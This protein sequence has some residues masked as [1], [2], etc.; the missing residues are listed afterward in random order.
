MRKIFLAILIVV[1]LLSVACAGDAPASSEK[2]LN[3][4]MRVCIIDGSP[5]IRLALKGAYSIC[6]IDTGKAIMDGSLLDTVVTGAKDG[7]LIGDKELKTYGVAVK[8]EKDSTIYVDG[9][10]FRGEIDVITKDGSKLMVINHI[11]VEDYLY[12]VLHHEVSDRWP[13]AALKAQAIAART[14]AIYQARQNKLQPYDLRSDIYSQV[15]GGSGSEKWATTKAVNLTRSKVLT[16][17]GELFPTYYHATCAGSTE[18]AAS[19]WNIN[20]PPLKGARCSF[21]FSS[22]HYKWAKEIPL[23]DIEDKLKK[24]GYNIGKISSVAVLSRNR[25]GRVDKLEIKDA[26][27]V[28]IVLKAKEFRQLLGPNEIRSTRFEAAVKQD[29]LA[30]TGRGWGHGVGMCQWG[31]YGLSKRGRTAEEIIKFYYPG[32]K[33]TSLDKIKDKP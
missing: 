11:P 27:G 12:G 21:C 28:S 32:A 10:R 19:L 20:I 16:Y 4:V 15:Y 7:L 17:K 13:I 33:I 2:D 6:A 30:V 25:S 8:V 1:N 26:S 3:P 14:F 18:D 29:R 23:S 5:S 9:K 24:S 31:A 22:P